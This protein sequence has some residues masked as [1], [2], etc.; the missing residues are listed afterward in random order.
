MQKNNAINQ[1]TQQQDLK[2]ENHIN[3][4]RFCILS[5]CKSQL[6]KDYLK[7]FALE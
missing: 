2:N 5:C 1:E 3:K 7:V 6:S 4:L